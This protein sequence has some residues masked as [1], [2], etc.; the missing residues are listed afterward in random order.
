M[1]RRTRRES[2]K[3]TYAFRCTATAT[4]A[5]AIAFAGL[6]WVMYQLCTTSG[7]TCGLIATPA[8]A[9]LS[10]GPGALVAAVSGWICAA[11]KL[12]REAA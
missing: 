10:V 6:M 11:R 8:K 9:L 4:A 7:N 1:R 3:Y 2:E 12:R 5:A